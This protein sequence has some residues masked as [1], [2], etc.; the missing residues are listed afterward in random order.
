M[1]PELP[2]LHSL[3]RTGGTLV[4]KCLACMPGH[5]LLS[6]VHPRAAFFDPMVQAHEWFGLL[7]ESELKAF[8]APKD[9]SYSDAIKFIHSRCVERGKKLI[10]RD[11]THVDFTPGSYPVK[12]TLHLSQVEEL[13][14]HFN[15]KNIALVRH[16]VDSYLSLIRLADYRGRLRVSTYLKGFRAYAEIAVKTGFVRFEDFCTQPAVVLGKVCDALGLEFDPDFE[17]RFS[18]YANITGDHYTS[19]QKVTLTGDAV[20]ERSSDLI[21]LPPHRPEYRELLGH[22]ANVPDFKRIV[23]LLGYRDQAD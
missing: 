14:R 21:S 2:V 10:I 22:L 4:S 9:K 3:A 17:K 12:P 6:E 8:F 20:G 15:V 1:K 23:K 19:D 16:P 7:T 13:S 18:G 5:V 11:W